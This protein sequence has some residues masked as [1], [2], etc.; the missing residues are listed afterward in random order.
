[1]NDKVRSY[2]SVGSLFEE[3]FLRNW[4]S[5]GKISKEIISLRR[6]MS[7]S[8]FIAENSDIAGGRLASKRVSGKSGGHEFVTVYK[9]AQVVT[10]MNA[11]AIPWQA[12]S[13]YVAEIRKNVF[14]HE[15]ELEQIKREVDQ[16]KNVRTRLLE[17]E[18][19]SNIFQNSTS[20]ESAPASKAKPLFPEGRPLTASDIVGLAGALPNKK[21]GVYFLLKDDAI[22]YVGKSK[23]LIGRIREHIKDESKEFNRFALLGTEVSTAEAIES[24]YISLLNPPLNRKSGISFS[25]YVANGASSFDQ[26]CN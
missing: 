19:R 15:R 22:V 24:Y 10:M 7:T 13:E 2:A 23:N 11:R 21:S 16:L 5:A 25:R 14:E 6:T 3:G 17:N 9:P 4:H 20:P 18:A 1:M 8:K 12:K 26:I